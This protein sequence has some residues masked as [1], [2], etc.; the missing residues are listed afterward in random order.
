MI[1]ALRRITA[2]FK[3]V[4][5]H[6]RA[7]REMTREIEAHLRLLEDDFRRAGLSPD[8]AALAARRAYGGVEQ[9]KEL[10]REER[11]IPWLDHTLQDLR[12]A[13][14]GLIKSPVF[15]VAATL[16]LALGIG[17]NTVILSNIKVVLLH[18]LPYP[19]ADRLD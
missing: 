2:R 17:A 14:R 8:D 1:P 12:Y 5:F 6:R 19:S 15:F 16:T 9:T 13:W 11:S 18:P 4:F 10:H 7:E 3:N